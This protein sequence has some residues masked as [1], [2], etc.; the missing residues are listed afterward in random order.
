MATI[1]D[2]L[3]YQDRTISSVTR[4]PG[5]WVIGS[6]DGWGAFFV[7][8][9][10]PVEPKPGMSVRF[11]GRGLGYTVRGLLLDGRIVYYR[12]ADEDAAKARRE[13]EERDRE[14]R[15][16]AERGRADM[17]RRVAALPAPLRDRIAAFRRN[18]PDFWLRF[19]GYEMAVCEQAA[20]GVDAEIDP[21]LSG[22]QA[23]CAALLAKPLWDEPS[24]IA[25]V[26]GAMC[27]LTGCREY[28]CVPADESTNRGA[29]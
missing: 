21:D 23:G 9:S 19:E 26:H 28:G 27:P 10:S 16:D 18:N 1:L 14:S 7:P 2:D 4:E 24:R 11:Y 20:R 8:D 29:K 12:T 3:E 17:D 25:A 5:G 13:A 22:N 15:Y 6:T